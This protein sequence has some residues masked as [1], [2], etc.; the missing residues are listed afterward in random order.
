MICHAGMDSEIWDEIPDFPGYYAST[1]GRIK[2]M[3]TE[4]P[5][6]GTHKR[7]GRY[8]QGTWEQAR[9]I[10]PYLDSKVYQRVQL[11]NA[12]GK[13]V[14]Q[15]VH[16]LVLLTW[17]GVPPPGTNASHLDGNRSNNHVDNLVWETQLANVRRKAAHGTQQ[18][19]E[20]HGASKLREN[21][22]VAIRALKKTGRFS[23]STIA[24]MFS[25]S[26][27]TIHAIVHNKCWRHVTS[28]E[29]G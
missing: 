2:S 9:L 23:Q 4:R 7:V 15:A 18:R 26:S 14:K 12:N 22:V 3:W 19:G 21:D 11:F 1:H 6:G 17:E 8:L 29:D 10:R 13:R 25:V 24:A 16:R 28:G 27:G 20:D 5:R